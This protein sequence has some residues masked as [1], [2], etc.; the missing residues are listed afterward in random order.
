MS[1]SCSSFC[2]LRDETV[3]YSSSQGPQ[4]L[5]GTRPI[6]AFLRKRQ[7]NSRKGH[8]SGAAAAAAC[9]RVAASVRA[10]TCTPRVRV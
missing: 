9:R 4:G 8:A 1:D 2:D 10:R 3:S 7:M 5:R 6:V